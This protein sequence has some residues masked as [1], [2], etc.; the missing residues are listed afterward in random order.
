MGFQRAVDWL[1]AAQVAGAELEST[2]GRLQDPRPY[3]PSLCSSV[4]DLGPWP[5]SLGSLTQGYP[6]GVTLTLILT[7]ITSQG[8]A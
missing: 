2:S 8:Q 3:L 4:P 6:A 7:S 5:S 1:V